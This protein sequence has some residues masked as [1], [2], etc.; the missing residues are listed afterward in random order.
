MYVIV[1]D[2]A[3]LTPG[4]LLLPLVIRVNP[5][6]R[7]R[8]PRGT[9]LLPFAWVAGAALAWRDCWN[10]LFMAPSPPPHRTKVAVP[11]LAVE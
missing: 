7:Q 1:A 6:N 11:C 5:V 10:A 9:A 3:V 2:T 8:P 4:A